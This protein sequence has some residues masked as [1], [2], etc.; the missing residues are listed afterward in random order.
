MHTT[1]TDPQTPAHRKAMAPAT[2]SAA[3]AAPVAKVAT[4]PLRGAVPPAPRKGEEEWPAGESES[5]SMAPA[6]VTPDPAKSATF[7]DTAARKWIM[8]GLFALVAL[9]TPVIGGVGFASSYT[10]LKVLAAANGFGSIAPWFPIGLD[11]GILI[12][13]AWDL[14][15]V[16]R[17][18]PWPLVRV[19]AHVLTLSTVGLNAVSGRRPGESVVDALWGDPTRA[20]MHGLMPALF[21]MGVEG[22][23]R[24]L[25]DIARLED[26]GGTGSIP[27]YRWFLSPFATPRVYRRMRLANIKSYDDLVARDQE[28]EGYKVWLIQTLGGD[29][30]KATDEQLL[31]VTMAPQGY[32]VREA[33]ALPAMWQAEADARETAEDLRRAEA[34]AAD[35]ERAA[36]EELRKAEAEAA[37][38]ERKAELEIVKL[39]AAARI[40]SAQARITTESRTAEASSEAEVAEAVSQ[41]EAAKTRAELSRRSAERLAQAEAEAEESAEAAAARMRAAEANRLAA[42]QEAAAAQKRAETEQAAEA[43]EKAAARERAETARVAEEAERLTALAERHKADQAQAAKFAAQAARDAAVLEQQA[44]DA[45]EAAA[46]ADL[47]ATA[48][49]DLVRLSPRERNGRR[50]ARLLI[51]AH[52]AGTPVAD[53]DIQAVP[54]ADIEGRLGVGRTV[55]SELRQEAMGLLESGYAPSPAETYAD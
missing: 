47:A 4:P 45:R 21:I 30:S 32:T 11:V 3:P 16:A 8:R 33:L 17:R 39:Q 55:A 2:P 53:I 48:A 12:F 15:M 28:L 10:T 5:V 37:E 36:A 41:A 27:L 42:E 22:A 35:A 13:L 6:A 52:P 25:I 29:L 18:R 43:A 24:L 19:V 31:P 26:G 50:V 14:I 34:E 1:L 38:A 44:A 7:R 23:R 51:A 20:V 54:L 40:K 46:R 9:G 49:D